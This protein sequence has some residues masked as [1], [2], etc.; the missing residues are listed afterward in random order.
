MSSADRVPVILNQQYQSPDLNTLQ[1]LWSRW[2]TDFTYLRG[3][4]DE[5]TINTVQMAVAAN[6]S[7][8]IGGLEVRPSGADLQIIAGGII[9]LSPIAPATDDPF[10]GSTL[11]SRRDWREL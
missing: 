2:L 10:T 3:K 9:Q 1:N 6:Y 4:R 11:G 7:A 8:V 5:P